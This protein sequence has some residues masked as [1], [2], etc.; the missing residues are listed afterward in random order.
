MEPNQVFGATVRQ[1]REARGIGLRRFAKAVELSPTYLS[2]VERG[3]LLPPAEDK[4]LA[5]AREL[6][7]DPDVLLAMAGRVASDLIEA[8]K[9]HP[10]ELGVLIR[11][12][13]KFVGKS[14][15]MSS[16]PRQM[17]APDKKCIF[18]D[19]NDPNLFDRFRQAVEE[20][21][22]DGK[23]GNLLLVIDNLDAGKDRNLF[24]RICQAVE[25]TKKDGNRFLVTSRSGKA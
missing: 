5:I 2:R 15:L 3:Q 20:A 8:I 6:D 18:L 4:V 22:K 21:K 12:A 16:V 7:Q 11:S 10:R 14:A 24:D 19:G 1:L 9:S 17:T 25:E 23:H 13:G